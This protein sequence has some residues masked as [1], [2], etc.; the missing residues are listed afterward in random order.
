[1]ER[2][3]TV[4]YAYFVYAYMRT[5]ESDELFTAIKYSST[6]FQLLQAPHSSVRAPDQ[7]LEYEEKKEK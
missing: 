7:E 4:L 1:M 6:S 5:E 3:G 2:S